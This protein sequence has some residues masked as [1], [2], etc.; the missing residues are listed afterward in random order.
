MSSISAHTKTELAEIKALIANTS[1]NSAFSKLN[2]LLDTA[3]KDEILLISHELQKI[4][5]SFFKKKK[6][7]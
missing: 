2:T 4:I 1:L 3:H 7:H 6:K 5:N